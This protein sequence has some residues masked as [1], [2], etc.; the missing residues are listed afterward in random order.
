MQ[1]PESVLA[2]MDSLLTSE[3]LEA[4]EQY[5]LSHPVVYSERRGATSPGSRTV[6]Y[7]P[8]TERLKVVSSLGV[9]SSPTVRGLYDPAPFP[10]EVRAY[11]PRPGPAKGSITRRE[12]EAVVALEEAPR[13]SNSSRKKEDISP[14]AEAVA[15]TRLYLERLGGKGICLGVSWLSDVPTPSGSV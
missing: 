5:R 7:K 1:T 10:Y 11:S 12:G 3:A 2:Q 15:R 14:E 9:V 6:Q 8:Q 4:R 13:K